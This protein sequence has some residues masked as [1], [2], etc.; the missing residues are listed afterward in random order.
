LVKRKR[1]TDLPLALQRSLGMGD[2]RHKKSP[3]PAALEED[4]TER[5]REE[6]RSTLAANKTRNRALGLHKGDPGYQISNQ[7]E[8]ADAIGVDKNLIKNMLGGVRAGTKTKLIQRST[9][10]GAIREALKLSAVSQIT[11]PSER[12]S[13]LLILAGLPADIFR[14]FEDAVKAQHRRTVR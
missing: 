5:F 3:P 14:G 7:A 1:T 13:V 6:V 2:E 10:V 11:V 4:V 9:Y 8:L 12:A